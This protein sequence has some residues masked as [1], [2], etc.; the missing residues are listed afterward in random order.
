MQESNPLVLEIFKLDN[1]LKMG[2]F[3]HEQLASTLRHYSQCSVSFA[4]IHTLCQETISALSKIGKK[5]QD[6]QGLIRSLQKTGQM[7]WEHLLTKPVKEALRST[8]LPDLILSLDEEL[9]YIPWELL[10]D[11]STFLCLNFNLGRVVRTKE[12]IS[13]PQYRS[14]SATMRMLILAN[15]TSDLKGAYLEGMFIKNQLDHKRK[16]IAIHFKSTSIDTLYVKKN[17]SDYDIVHFAGHCEYDFNNPA[18]S[19]WVFR[20]GTFTAQDILALGEDFSLPSLVF[21][22]ACSSAKTGEDSIGSDYQEKSYSLACAFLYSGVRHYLGAAR[23]I[24]D[25]VSLTFAKE[26]YTQLTLGSSV[27]ESVRLGRL[28]LI[29][30]YGIG[31]MHWASYLLYGDPN[32]ILFRG[33]PKPLKPRKTGRLFS[34]KRPLAWASL[35]VFLAALAAYLY[36][37]LP[38]R[39]PNTYMLFLKS[40]KLFQKGQNEQVLLT[41]SSIIRK[42]P[43]FLAAYPLIADTYQRLGDRDNALKNYF[44]YAVSSE[45]RND[46]K[47]LA[48]AYNGIGW[49]YYL[50]GDYPKAYDFYSKALSLSQKNHDKLNE[51]VALRK[52]G[53]WHMDKEDDEKALKLLTRSAEINRER[54]Y[55]YAHK[56][57]LA[58]DY[59]NIG[60]L[61]A[62]KEGLAT[63]RDFYTKSLRLFEA[64]KLKHELSDCYFNLGEVYKMGKQYQKAL[65]FYERGLKID[66]DLGHAL[67]LAGDYDMIGELYMEMGD[68]PQAEEHFKKALAVACPIDAKLEIASA[69][70]NLGLLYKQKGY[71]NKAR[72]HLRQAQ[73]IYSKIDTSDYEMV[74][75]EL[76]TLD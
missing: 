33:K 11:A 76:L 3:E 35:A 38:S 32:F 18:R 66:E 54:Q 51:A 34:Y 21:S 17:L 75:E 24:E 71:K 64:L 28:K 62:Q 43:L 14:L 6:P 70:F 57:H 46:S 73:E 23:K 20:D 58:R 13:S 5:S 31:A 15:P 9:I 53:L 56:A 16:Q 69:S 74:K 60:L 72:E 8:K 48:S 63:A 22:N 47:H 45:K 1:A 55:L 37:S 36:I 19:G 42:D 67:N 25:P 59:F 2:V 26:F 30:E 41:C 7:L 27:G 65:D 61:F 40:K 68:W 44:N 4:Q 12:Q 49:I 29:K 10:C 52:M 50:N 39:N